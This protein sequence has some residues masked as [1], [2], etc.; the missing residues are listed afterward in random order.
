MKKVFKSDTIP[1]IEGKNKNIYWQKNIF[2]EI[3]FD[4][5]VKVIFDLKTADIVN[6]RL[7]F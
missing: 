5:T 2:W 4:R 7:T 1:K 6:G 3:R